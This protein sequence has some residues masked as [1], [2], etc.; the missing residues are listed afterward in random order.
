MEGLRKNA[1]K[2]IWKKDVIE[3]KDYLMGIDWL[4]KSDIL[5]YLLEKNIS[6]VIRPSGTEP[7]SW[8]IEKQTAS[9]Y[10]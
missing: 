6:I 5:K 2:N 10:N 3:M 8:C 9:V 4:S 7:I 1:L